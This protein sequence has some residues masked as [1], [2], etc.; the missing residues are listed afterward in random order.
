M[1]TA[2]RHGMEGGGEQ[3]N[4]PMAA[5]VTLGEALRMAKFW[6]L[7]TAAITFF[8]YGGQAGRPSPSAPRIVLRTFRAVAR[9]HTHTYIHTYCSPSNPSVSWPPSLTAP[10][11]P[12]CRDRFSSTCIC[13]TFSSK[14]AERR[15]WRLLPSTQSTTSRALPAKS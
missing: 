4:K 8:L 2:G 7:V 10:A 14:T 3:H 13:P 15:P 5:N 12:R 6:A 1:W 9:T 11:P